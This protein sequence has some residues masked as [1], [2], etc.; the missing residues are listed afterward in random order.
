MAHGLASDG[1][2]L[3]ALSSSRRR[4]DSTYGTLDKHVVLKQSVKNDLY[5]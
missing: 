3:K 5:A 1:A 4:M 2:A